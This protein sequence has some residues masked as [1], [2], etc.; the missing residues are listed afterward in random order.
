MA[1]QQTQRELKMVDIVDF[2]MQDKPIKVGD[3][4]N[5][6]ISDKVMTSLASR[7]QEVSAKMFADKIEEPASVQEPTV[8]EP[9]AET[10]EAQ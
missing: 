8:E 9:P 4:F 2:S 6:L 3:A 1:E 7:K 5:T 10:T